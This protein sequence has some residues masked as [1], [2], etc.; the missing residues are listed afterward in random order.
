MLLDPLNPMLCFVT[1]IEEKHTVPDYLALLEEIVAGGVTHVQFRAKALSRFETYVWVYAIKKFLD[2]RNIP[3]IINDSV[4]LTEVVDAYGVHL[5]QTDGSPDAARLRLGPDKCI[6][7]SVESL[8]ELNAA[9]QL[10]SID[11]V[12]ASAVFPTQTKNN[13]KTIWGLEGLGQFVAHSKHPV[14]A[15]GGINTTNIEDVMAE[16]V[17]GV[18]VI[19]A[20]QQSNTIQ[21]TT[22]LLKEAVCYATS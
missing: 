11:Y 14:L 7:I 2:A 19:S 6:G 10:T 3:L 16:G 13:C 8:D 5:G 18:A 22:Q 1:H 21:E 12:A 15:I 4:A 9:N 20:I 17:W